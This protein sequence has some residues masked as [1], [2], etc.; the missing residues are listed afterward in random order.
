[1]GRIRKC[2]EKQTKREKQ[3]AHQLNLISKCQSPNIFSETHVI[4]KFTFLLLLFACR[5]FN[6]LS[7]DLLLKAFMYQLALYFS[8]LMQFIIH[9]IHYLLWLAES[10]QWI[11]KNQNLGCHLAADYKII[12][13]TKLKV[14]GNNVMFD[15]SSWFLRVIVS[16]SR[17]LRCL[18]IYIF[19]H[20]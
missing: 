11:F 9:S 17:A 1:M 20:V 12:M 10:I 14:T 13:W 7:F 6:L 15:R 16:S 5:Y 19:L 2:S 18:L 4:L 3:I 8:P